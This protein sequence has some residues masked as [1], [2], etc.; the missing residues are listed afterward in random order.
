MNVRSGHGAKGHQLENG[1]VLAVGSYL[2]SFSADSYQNVFRDKVYYH[3]VQLLAELQKKNLSEDTEEQAAAQ[4]HRE[5]VLTQFYKHVGGA[6]KFK[7]HSACFCCLVA[8]P[9]HPL[10]CGHILCTPCLKA[11]SLSHR[12]SVIEIQGCPLHT[13]RGHSTPDLYRVTLKPDAAGV[14]VLTLDG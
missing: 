7:S 11:N 13:T 8:P 1:K 4:I 6:E 2:S 5:T 12:K 10:P 14:R 9:Q 3:L